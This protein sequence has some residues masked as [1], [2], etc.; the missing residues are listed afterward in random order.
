MASLTAKPPAKI[1]KEKPQKINKERESKMYSRSTTTD[2]IDLRSLKS[3][4]LLKKQY[5]INRESCLINPTCRTIRNSEHREAEIIT[6][7]KIPSLN[8]EQS[9]LP[10]E[11][12]TPRYM[13]AKKYSELRKVKKNRFL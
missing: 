3:H 11:V 10:E 13:M 9:S 4:S 7:F 5:S 8:F 2:L 1:L 6:N 12:K